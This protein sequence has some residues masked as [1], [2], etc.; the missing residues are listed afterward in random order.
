MKGYD[1]GAI[2]KTFSL[3]TH[4]L[5]QS[6]VATQLGRSHL[7]V[8]QQ[9]GF[10]PD[11]ALNAAWREKVREIFTSMQAVANRQVSYT[12]AQVSAYLQFC[13]ILDA[14]LAEAKRDLTT[15]QFYDQFGESALADYWGPAYQSVY[16]AAQV[17]GT[18]PW[19]RWN[20]AANRMAGEFP[21]I[22][23]AFYSHLAYLL[24][25]VFKDDPSNRWHFIY[26]HHF[27]RSFNDT[28]P[29]YTQA[30]DAVEAMLSTWDTAMA[31]GTTGITARNVA[32]IKGD[33]L[34]AFGAQTN[35]DYGV[36]LDFHQKPVP[37]YDRELLAQ[38]NQMHV[39]PRTAVFAAASP[40]VDLTCDVPYPTAASYVA[41]L[42]IQPVVN[43]VDILPDGY[44]WSNSSTSAVSP[45]FR[46]AIDA[47]QQ[48]AALPLRLTGP[49]FSGAAALNQYMFIED[50]T[51]VLTEDS[52]TGAYV[53]TLTPV[54]TFGF[55]LGQT[56]SFEK[57]IA[58]NQYIISY[59]PL[60]AVFNTV[61]GG[62]RCNPTLMRAIATLDSIDAGNV[63][64]ILY[65]ASGTGTTAAD[66]QRLYAAEPIDEWAA[67][68][69]S[70]LATYRGGCTRALVDIGTTF[71]RSV[72]TRERFTKDNA[73]VV[74]NSSVSTDSKGGA[75]SGKAQKVGS[76]KELIPQVAGAVHSGKSGKF[77]GKHSG[78]G[79]KF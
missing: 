79:G 35:R 30:L 75:S 15:I 9:I 24:G 51:A 31:A 74:R 28:T 60:A 71:A 59:Y 76:I 39:C 54:N 46:A 63:E 66:V 78:R 42:L 34:N 10:T 73:A 45:Q 19:F 53:L 2:A 16:A 11:A 21:H 18:G 22:N 47:M 56:W 62:A 65:R 20:S 5:E 55:V 13:L 4:T 37:V 68:S 25:N 38:L 41:A 33:L 36:I 69:K 3:N 8:H 64:V 58:A 49:A 70:T 26:F 77:G 67:I 57:S 40:Q 72:N 6:A 32:D 17:D 27:N 43:N 14:A 52:S 23:V 44:L 1:F 48:A 61:A 50:Y 12:E 7:G 29:S